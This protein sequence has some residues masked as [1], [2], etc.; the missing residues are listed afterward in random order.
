[1]RLLGLIVASVAL[2]GGCGPHAPQA[3]P[4]ESSV[5]QEQFLR[6][7]GETAPIFFTQAIA[8]VLL[9]AAT[10]CP[11][12]NAYAPEVQRL[13]A[14]F[15]PRGVQFLLVYPDV[16]LRPEAAQK[17]RLAFEYPFAGVLDSRLLL[18]RRYGLRVVPEAAVLSGKGELLYRGRIDDRYPEFG[19]RRMQVTKTELR[20][21]L[22]AILDNNPVPIE[23][24][25]AIGC[26]IDFSAL[27]E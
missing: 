8:T 4:N 7:T 6:T 27:S 15:S 26:D 18:A 13:F 17:H 25:E 21:A 16:T 19:K 22:L 24:T 10:D 3:T 23:R 14:E 12:S 5:P 11:I 9:F 2:L 1:M 20:D